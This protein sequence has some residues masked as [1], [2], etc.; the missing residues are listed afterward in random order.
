M[1]ASIISPAVLAAAAISSTGYAQ[2]YSTPY[3][4]GT[5]GAVTTW[6]GDTSTVGT[7]T[8]NRP[9]AGTPPTA[10]SGAGTAVG[11]NTFNFVPSLTGIYAFNSVNNYDEYFHIYSPSF[12]AATPL[13]NVRF[14]SDATTFNTPTLTA[15]TAYTIVTSGFGNSNRGTYANTLTSPGIPATPTYSI[16]DNSAASVT[17]TFDLVITDPG[18]IVSFNSVTLTNFLHTWAG[19]IVATLTHLESGK[20]VDLL[21]RAGAT[22]AGGV[23]S[24][25]DFA[26]TYTLVDGGAALPTTTVIAPGTYGVL[27]NGT[28]GES[29]TFNNP[30]SFFVGDTI[31]GTW[32]L[33]VTDRGATDLGTISAFSIN[34]TVPTP[35]AAAL[36]GLAGLGALRRRR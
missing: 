29:S 15:G 19:D 36:L 14:G 28:V 12:N 5:P 23:G 31:A 10:L 35:S 20:T 27:A 22:T 26:G 11:Y 32:R 3:T 21:D 8:F 24:G 9:L 25:S 1:R 30:L 7:P 17:S 6:S 4:P 33:S 13:T 34:V 18:N 16:T 2:T